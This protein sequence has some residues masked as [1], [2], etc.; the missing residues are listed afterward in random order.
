MILI[1]GVSGFVGSNL[2]NYLDKKEKKVI[3]VSR[4]PKNIEVDFNKIDKIL[5]NSVNYF[6]HL[7]GK[8]HDLKK[9][10]EAATYYTVNTELTKKLFNQFLDSDCE[11]FIYMSS[12]KAV[13]DKANVILTENEL[14]N[15]KTHYGKSKLLAEN[16]ILSKKIPKN[17]RV[18]ILRPCMIHGKGN[19]GNLNLLYK[20]VSKR[21]PWILGA[22]KN[23]RSYC[24]I[25]NLLFIINE[26]MD[27]QSIPNGIYNV[28]DDHSLSTNDII[29]LIADSQSKKP[30]IWDISMK[31]IKIIAE[32]GDYLPLPLNS[33][34]L[35]KL[36]ESYV[37]SNKKI[38]DAIK[39]PLPLN[40]KEG[41]LTTFK[42]FNLN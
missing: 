34:R 37:V 27:N 24:S 39:K 9:T 31:L 40:S 19:K 41:M 23:K 32:I 8:A 30:I 20:L 10:S 5:L 26:L 22:F 29:S 4:S 1:T 3:G 13:V 25:E 6:I 11:V 36:T 15:P 28:A 17:K 21:I 12:V 33:E 42:S 14:P 38:I 16:Y 7:A 35:T 18:Y 2:N